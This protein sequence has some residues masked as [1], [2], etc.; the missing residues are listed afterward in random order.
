[1]ADGE[2]ILGVDVDARQAEEKIQRLTN[3]LAKLKI[4]NSNLSPKLREIA[5]EAG[6]CEQHILRLKNALRNANDSTVISKLNRE[7]QANEQYL[8][9]LINEYSKI[10]SKQQEIKSSIASINKEIGNIRKEKIDALEE[11]HRRAAQAADEQKQATRELAVNSRTLSESM[12]PIPNLLNGVSRA[13]SR[14]NR[15]ATSAFVFNIISAG[16]RRMAKW[17]INLLYLDQDF[18]NSLKQIKANLLTAFAPIYQAVLPLLKKLAEAIVWVT[19]Y[20]AKLISLLTGKPIEFNQNAARAMDYEVRY[21]TALGKISKG[22]TKNANSIA[23]ASKKRVKNAV[24]IEKASKKVDKNIKGLNKKLKETNSLLA[25]FDKIDVLKIDKFNKLDKLDKLKVLK[26]LGKAPNIA[27]NLGRL[28]GLKPLEHLDDLRDLD[29]IDGLD[30]LKELDIPESNLEFK[31]LGDWNNNAIEW[32]EKTND[33]INKFKQI[34]DKLEEIKPGSKKL[35][36]SLGA[37]ALTTAGLGILTKGKIFKPIG[38]FLIGSVKALKTLGGNAKNFIKPIW[39]GIKGSYKT[40]KINRA[41]TPSWARALKTNRA[42]TPFLSRIKNVLKPIGVGIKEAFKPIKETSKKYFNKGTWGNIKNFAKVHPALTGALAIGGIATYGANKYFGYKDWK[43]K[44]PEEQKKGKN[45]WQLFG[46]YFKMTLPSD[47]LDFSSLFGFKSSDE[48]FDETFKK[49]FERWL[50]KQSPEFKSNKSERELA[51]EY[52]RTI[53]AANKVP[54]KNEGENESKNESKKEYKN[55]NFSI[56][57][58][59]KIDLNTGKTPLKFDWKKTQQDIGE[60]LGKLGEKFKQFF[61]DAGENSKL[62]WGKVKE[63]FATWASNAKEKLKIM[64]ANLKQFFINIGEN[65]KEIWKKA[66]EKFFEWKKWL[67]EKFENIKGWFGEKFEWIGKESEKMWEAMKKAP[68]SALNWLLEK[69]EFLLNKIIGGL[70]WFIEQANK[71]G[72]DLPDWAGGGH[73]GINISKIQEVK[74]PRLAKGSVLKGGDPF[75][76]WVNDQPKG[77]TN[78]EA[79]LD[80]IVRAFKEVAGNNS[81]QNIVIEANGDLGGII[82]EL[83]FRLKNENRRIGTEIMVPSGVL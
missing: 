9:T 18:L 60:N 5:Q 54:N 70:N 20:L 48:I 64:I 75:L 46:D 4:N 65:S 41:F 8:K 53:P 1:M 11:S 12:L 22:R 50:D 14:I 30:G 79:P 66:K 38:K 25:K 69:T 61:N 6:L 26:G 77:Q 81:N 47:L 37:G 17:I 74:I 35:I 36:K 52:L 83:N 68:K 43:E 78:V 57:G 19:Q 16:F 80:T 67:G 62:L 2:I 49:P 42:A 72:F 33:F 63:K 51:M 27:E 82:R 29:S 55:P 44:L 58:F 73:F 39:Q 56:P 3:E 13:L 34:P 15:L 76:A 32:A 7:I 31:K 59:G 28:D 40:F 10:L 45:G 23:N 71:I 21:S 24:K